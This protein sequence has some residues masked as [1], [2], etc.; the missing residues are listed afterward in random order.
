MSQS[1]IIAFALMVGF[2]VWITTKGEL[3]KYRAVL[4]V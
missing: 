4:G 1:S 3:P 2:I